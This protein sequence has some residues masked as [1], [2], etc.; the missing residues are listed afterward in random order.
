[1]PTREE[2]LASPFYEEEV[3]ILREIPDGE[4]Y[5]DYVLKHI[6]LDRSNPKNS[7]YMFVHGKVDELDMSKPCAFTGSSNALPDID[8]D[9]P[10]DYREKAI[11]YVRDKYGAEKVCQITTFGRY[12]GRS[13]LKA[14]MRAESNIDHYTAGLITQH[15]PDEAAVSDQLEA[16]DEPSVIR[17]ALES[18]NDE[19][20]EFCRIENDELIG[21]YAD[22][23]KKALRLEG[24]FQN[25]GKHAAGVIISSERISDICP[26]SLGS[27]GV[28]Q[29][30]MDMKA[31]EK[32]GLVKFD[33]LGVDI[34]N[35]IQE[36]MGTEILKVPL[37][38][39]DVWDTI[40]SGNT[41]GI[42]Q[43]ENKL[44]RDWAEQLKPHNIEELAALV[45]IIRPGTLTAKHDD[46]RNMTKLYCDRKNGEVVPDTESNKVIDTY[47]VLIYQET[48]QKICS[49]LA[50]FTS[51]D[52]I[53]MMKS[54]GKK[55]AKLLFSLEEQFTGGCKKVNRIDEKETKEL[56]GNIKKS[57]RYLFNKSHAV[58]YSYPAYW[59]AYI[60]THKTLEF[61]KTWLTYS[62]S[63]MYPQEEVRAL[64]M[65][66]RHDHIDILPPS[67]HYLDPHFFIQGESVVFGLTHIKGASLHEIEK[68]FDLMKTHGIM[69]S[70]ASYLTNILP[71]VNKRTVD[72]L[73][74]CGCFQ[75]LQVSR[76]KLS[77]LYECICG[78]GGLTDKELAWINEREFTDIES[79][80][81]SAARSKKDGGACATLSRINKVHNILER[82]RNPGREMH[83]LPSKI[84]ATEEAAIGIPLSCSYMDTCLSDTNADTTCREAKHKP[85]KITLKVRVKEVKEHIIA[86]SGKTMGFITVSDDTAELDNLVVFSDKYETFG[87]LL[88]EGAMV[89][90]L[91]NSDNKGGK[92]SVIID[93]VI[94]L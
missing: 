65:S 93:R 55:N 32:L 22:I 5:Y 47:G 59:A 30:A 77:H 68:L 20:A 72:A 41:K 70:V 75:Y 12:S 88:F 84:A 87:P 89:G 42:F 57:A 14:V 61:Y 62:S 25:K 6:D 36:V 3:A 45:S 63:K 64:V 43:I 90:I 48:L 18:G 80:L 39:E 15:V 24:T 31:L 71:N 35:K 21:D 10:T 76:A 82:I 11:D 8:V 4:A 27:D 74:G 69:A 67:C 86:K 66:A 9:F 78:K 34:L 26:M 56:F 16:M 91:G 17:W 92:R 7:Y 37:D 60:K 79:A 33:F 2:A 49:Q 52:G 44:G 40:C 1:M 28:R 85:G 51:A 83:D 58:S 53:K 13:A 19:L 81:T 50:A 23:F 38:D 73:I 94:E 46:G 29:A 54:V